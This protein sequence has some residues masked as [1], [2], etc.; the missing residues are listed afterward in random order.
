MRMLNFLSNRF[1]ALCLGLSLVIY[2]AVT[3]IN[4]SR[5]LSESEQLLAVY[6]E[7]IK[8]QEDVKRELEAEEAMVGTDEYTEKIARQRLG[9]CKSNEKLF[10]DSKSE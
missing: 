3:Y 6:E 4:Q 1:V 2:V 10:V 9:L 7:N 8:I 5:V